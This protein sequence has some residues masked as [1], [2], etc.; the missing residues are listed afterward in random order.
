VHVLYD[1]CLLPGALPAQGRAPIPRQ[2]LELRTQVR[3][4]PAFGPDLRIPR[5]PRIAMSSVRH[6]SL[7]AP[8]R[9]DLR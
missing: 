2:E 3:P 9:F 4:H 8:A 1:R 6:S 5:I 7:V